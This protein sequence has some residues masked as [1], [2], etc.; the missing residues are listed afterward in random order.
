MR[1]YNLTRQSTSRTSVVSSRS[2]AQVKSSW[3]AD[4]ALGESLEI[5]LHHRHLA[6]YIVRKGPRRI[7]AV[8]YGY[9][10][11][12]VLGPHEEPIT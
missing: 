4:P 12:P 11:P 6:T 7:R 10:W 2:A 3:E 8:R 9:R 1:K 5:R